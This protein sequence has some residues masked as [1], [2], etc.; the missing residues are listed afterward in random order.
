[1]KDKVE[2]KKERNYEMTA[3]LGGKDLDK[4]SKEVVKKI[5]DLLK[6]AGAAVLKEEDWGIK[7][8]VYPIKKQ[9]EGYFY[10][11]QLAILPENLGKMKESLRLEESVLRYLL[12][13]I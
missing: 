2:E 13:K 11:W 8:L 9:K 3:I 10:F 7:E 4:K 1:M 5:G 6:K 12:I